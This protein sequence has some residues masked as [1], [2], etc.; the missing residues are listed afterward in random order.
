MERTVRSIM[1][2]LRYLFIDG[3]RAKYILAK[4]GKSSLHTLRMRT[5]PI[6]IQN[7]KFSHE[8]PFP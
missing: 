4:Q 5:S 6:I 7:E 2:S 3:N 8:I 1:E